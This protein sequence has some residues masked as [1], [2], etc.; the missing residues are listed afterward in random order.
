MGERR[1]SSANGP[2]QVPYSRHVQGKSEARSPCDLVMKG[3]ITS[4]VVY[5]GAIIELA[6]RY[7]FKNIGG[8]SAGAIAA[9]V[10]AA[11]EYRRQRDSLE[12][13]PGLAEVQRQLAEPGFVRDMFQPAEGARPAFEV[14]MRLGNKRA[15]PLRRRLSALG[16]LLRHEP[17]PMV[18]ALALAAG[19]AAVA[20]FE[21]SFDRAGEV[22]LLAAGSLALAVLLVALAIGGAARMTL[23]QLRESLDEN[24]YGIVPGER[25]TSWLHETIQACAGL[26]RNEPL[27][28]AMLE[29]AE[30]GLEMMTTDLSFAR[31]VRLPVR[32]EK[33]YG[34]DPGEMRRLFPPVVLDRMERDQEP[35]HYFFPTADLP[36]VVAVRM[37]LSFPP[38]MSAVRLWSP[39][40][41]KPGEVME[42]WFSDGGISSNFPIH[43]F[44]SWLPRH[45]TFG[46][47]L[48]EF[49]DWDPDARPVHLPTAEEEE[50]HPHWTGVETLGGFIKQIFDVLENWRD[51]M[52]TELP[53]FRDRVCQVRLRPDEGGLN[54]DMPDEAIA[55]LIERGAEAG[56]EIN[57]GFDWDAHVMT[58]YL[59]LMQQLEKNLKDVR[60]KFRALPE[61]DAWEAGHGEEWRRAAEK[62]TKE[63]LEVVQDWGPPPAPVG[64]ELGHEP[65]PE[66][67]MRVTPRA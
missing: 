25:L 27:T 5:P 22:A 47:D 61:C 32:D 31:P 65:K 58:R 37:S 39:H 43:F 63:L 11:A 13:L 44:D 64:F 4:G 35:G 62:A 24:F 34:F 3:G 42:N 9:A 66:P 48:Q 45:P 17:L 38:L 20:V 6:K 7:R 26:P 53:G 46:L 14:L 55:A 59:T 1:S 50:P 60:D 40:P 2:A 56:R 41:R 28:F 54:L 12:E 51:S 29:E 67:V 36:V 21:G 10:T 16:A 49:P 30:I 57:R 33:A 19:L 52:Q 18:I 8:T 23:D 15:R